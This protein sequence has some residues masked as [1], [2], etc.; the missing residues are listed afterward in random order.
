MTTLFRLPSSLRCTAYI[1][2]FPR[3]RSPR[4]YVRLSTSTMAS[5]RGRT[6]ED[7]IALLN[8]LQSNRVIISSI[9]NAPRDMNFDA[10]PEM[11][12]WTRK[13]GYD[14]RDFAERG[15]RCVHVAGTKGKGSTCV[16]VE[17]LL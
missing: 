11:L 10:I 7:A 4:L 12:E 1:L 17:N 8:S 14:P 2:S 16:M 6:Y 13:A 3:L 5:S 15:L 9:S